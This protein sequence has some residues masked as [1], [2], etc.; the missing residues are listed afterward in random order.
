[1]SDKSIEKHSSKKKS[2]CADW[3]VS[4]LYSGSD[5]ELYTA[6]G[7]VAG[8]NT[9][10]GCTVWRTPRRPDHSATPGPLP[11]AEP[12]DI[13]ARIS[14]LVEQSLARA[15]PAALSVQSLQPDTSKLTSDLR[16]SQP[17]PPPPPALQPGRAL[18]LNS[19]DFFSGRTP[20]DTA[21]GVGPRDDGIEATSAGRSP[22]PFA[23]PPTLG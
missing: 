2:K 1:M 16:L 9:H 14:R 23:G 21:V 12:E 20:P 3:A 11:A 18:P 7:V 10:L 8:V 6:G 15:L 19:V 5:I 17:L 4:P 13:D 22:S